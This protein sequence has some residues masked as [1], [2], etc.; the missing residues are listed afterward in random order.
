M[1]KFILTVVACLGFVAAN[2]QETHE[3]TIGINYVKGEAGEITL[4]LKSDENDVSLIQGFLF[5]PEGL[6][7]VAKKKNAIIEGDAI[8]DDNDL[9]TDI[10]QIATQSAMDTYGAEAV[11]GMQCWQFLFRDSENV[12]FTTVGGNK[13]VGFAYNASDVEDLKSVKLCKILLS[14]PGKSKIN[15]DEVKATGI[16]GIAADKAEA[17]N[18]GK[19]VENNRVVIKK[20]GVKYSTTGQVIK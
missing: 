15:I 6:N 2:A 11:P 5:V 14:R 10:W 3:V 16:K 8:T 18:D 4:N 17:A 19:F 1:K 12:P 9:T 20:A 13:V 7:V